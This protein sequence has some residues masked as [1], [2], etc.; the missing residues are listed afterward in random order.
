MGTKTVVD[1]P[2]H[3]IT[4]TTNHPAEMGT[5]TV[6]IRDGYWV[7]KRV[8]T[9]PAIYATRDKLVSAAYTTLISVPVQKTKVVKNTVAEPGTNVWVY[10]LKAEYQPTSVRT[11]LNLKG[12]S[13]DIIGW[14]GT[15]VLIDGN[16]IYISGMYLNAGSNYAT[17]KSIDSAI[18]D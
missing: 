1:V 9:R 13:N 12:F 7:Y 14:D 2:G 6:T 11:Y 17:P 10:T 18:V 16:K 5:Y 4:L 15:N 8:E 3:Y